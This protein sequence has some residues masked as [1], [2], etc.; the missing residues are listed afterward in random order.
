MATLGKERQRKWREKQKDKKQVTVLLSKDAY[1][2]LNRVKAHKGDSFS[3]ILNRAVINLSSP[4][5]HEVVEQHQMVN[6]LSKY[7]GRLEKLVK[8]FTNELTATNE[9]LRQEILARLQ[10]EKSFK[11]SEQRFRAILEN[12]YDVIF[13]ANLNDPTFEY[14]SPSSKRI[15]GYTP[16]EMKDLGFKKLRSFVHPDDQERFKEHF[17]VFTKRSPGEKDVTIE[18]RMKHKTLGYR[19]M[20]S[21]HALMFDEH[22]R[23]IAVIGSVRDIH[24]RKQAEIELQQLHNELEQKVKERTRS[25]EEANTALRLMLKKELEVKTELEDKIQSNVNELVIP[26]IEKLKTSRL[27]TSQKSYIDVIESNLKEIISPFLRTLSSKFLDLTP[28]EIQVAN[29][30]KH[31]RTTKEIADI[32]NLSTRTIEFHRANIRKKVGLKNKKASLTSHLMSLR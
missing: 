32:L 10:V 27:N 7:R 26:F 29:F 12:T 22:N 25:L 8:A 4:L 1:N 23:P 9:Q 18:M 21:T 3:N 5:N 6:E 16:E 30:I 15:F 14:I 31:G 17:R 28:G 2:K 19:W 11:E 20:S 13:R 24:R